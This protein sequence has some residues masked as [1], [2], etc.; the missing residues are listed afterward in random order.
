MNPAL[1]D[2]KI[3]EARLLLRQYNFVQAVPAYEKLARQNPH[4]AGIWFEYGCAAGGAGQLDLLDRAWAK[5][6]ELEPR[7]S[8]LALKIGHHYQALRQ[9]QKARASFER[10]ASLDPRGINPRMA[11]AIMLEQAHRFAEAREAIASCLAIDPK[12]D[13]ARYFAALLDRRENKLEA[14]ERALRDLI[15]AGP[16]HPYVQYASRYELAEV[17]NRTER[18]DEAMEALAEAKRF[19]RAVGD[20]NAMLAEYDGEAAKYRRSTQS[21]PAGAL[22]AWAKEFPEKSRAAVP[23]L[24]FLGGHPRSGTTLLEQV[25]GA[26]P[27]VAAL[28]ESG[29]F[30]RIAAPAF[31]ATGQ[32]SPARLNIIRRLYIDAMQQQLGP[33]A[34]GKLILDKNPS[35]TLKLRI[36]LRLFPELRVIIALRDPRDV[37]V[38]CYFQNIPLNPFNANFLS[39][40]RAAIHYANMM[41]VWLAVRQWEGFAWTETRYE[42]IV[43]DMPKEGRRV[44]EFL[45]LAWHEDQ[46]R[47]HEK[48]GSQQIYSPTYH[49]ASQPVYKRSVARWKVYEK[50]LAPVQPILEPYCRAFGYSI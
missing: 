11:I 5:A 2:K 13:Q 16:R 3:N 17:L 50:H 26:H 20:V 31:N 45:G 35:P 34:S 9:H 46:A 18:F 7:N 14:A 1:A 41:D 22:R 15:A 29:A 40:E 6:L 12:D 37:V 8:D 10:A 48:S 43:A 30:T 49:D 36:W 33:A 27:G 32:V 38:S 28:D 23:P 4:K 21:L 47:F 24:A 25:L 44:T 39:L 42:D 19:T